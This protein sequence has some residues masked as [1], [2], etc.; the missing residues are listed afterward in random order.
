MDNHVRTLGFLYLIYHAI[1]LVIG[2]LVFFLLSGIG[3]ISGDLEA[4]GILGL[5]GVAIAVFMSL[6]A[7]PGLIAG[8]GLL[9]RKNWGRILAIILGCFHLFEVPIGT[10]LGVYTLWV[11]T[12]EDATPLFR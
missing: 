2:I 7:A 4:A 6:L 8:F 11:L 3:I 9:A 5:I 1:A 12:H 10:A